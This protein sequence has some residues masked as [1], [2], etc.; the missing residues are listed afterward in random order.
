MIITEKLRKIIDGIED[1]DHADQSQ[2][3]QRREVHHA[4]GTVCLDVDSAGGSAPAPAR[5][6]T[7]GA[8]RGTR[9]ARR[10]RAACHAGRAR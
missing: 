5:S 9:A 8:A 6:R 1:K 2:A 3:G 4:A 7:G 10:A